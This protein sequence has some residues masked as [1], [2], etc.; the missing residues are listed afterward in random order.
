MYFKGRKS[1]Y[2]KSVID[3]KSSPST[4]YLVVPSAI[5]PTVVK[6]LEMVNGAVTLYLA[7]I[8][9]LARSS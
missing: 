3:P 8:S 7:K 9:C 4:A 2:L 5:P 6:L 1:T